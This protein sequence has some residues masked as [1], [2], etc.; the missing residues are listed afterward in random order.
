MII[1]VSAREDLSIQLKARR[2]HLG[3]SL[4]QVARR[5]GTSTASL[6]R[7]ENSWRRFEIATLRKLAASLGCRLD[8]TL[9]PVERLNGSGSVAGVKRLRRLFWDH[10]LVAGDLKE[11]SR[12]VVSRV[13]EYGDLQDIRFL[14]NELGTER[15]LQLTATVRFSSKKAAHFWQSIR[16]MEGTICAKKLSHPAAGE[17]WRP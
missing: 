15:F 17:F 9:V 4:G 11:H 12:W 1:D 3:L 6:C 5:A 10:A 7:Y 13:V 8:V 14:A 16:T 2:M